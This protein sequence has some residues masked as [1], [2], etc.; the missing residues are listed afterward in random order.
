MVLSSVY[1]VCLSKVQTVVHYFEDMYI[2]TKAKKTML[3]RINLSILSPLRLE[4]LKI[5]LL[6]IHV[7]SP[8]F[9]KHYYVDDFIIDTHYPTGVSFTLKWSSISGT[10]ARMT[11]LPQICQEWY[12]IPI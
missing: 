8:Y 4:Q 1:H 3:G 10:V 9:C 12:I 2:L 6:I 11:N 5:I 7:G